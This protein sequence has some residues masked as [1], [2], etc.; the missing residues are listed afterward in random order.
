MTGLISPFEI[1]LDKRL[2]LVKYKKNIVIHQIS[3]IQS[4]TLTV[5]KK[6]VLDC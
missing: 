3:F 4:I 1:L 2:S 6:D 5:P